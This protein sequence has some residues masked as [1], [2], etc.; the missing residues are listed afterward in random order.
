VRDWPPGEGT[1]APGGSIRGARV[2][3]LS[4]WRH[5]LIHSQSTRCPSAP[6][7]VLTS[8]RGAAVKRHPRACRRPC[9]SLSSGVPATSDRRGLLALA[10][11]EATE[12]H[13]RWR[14]PDHQC[15]PLDRAPTRGAAAYQD[16]GDGRVI[17]A[18]PSCQF[19]LG[20]TSP[21]ELASEPHGEREI[22]PVRRSSDLAGMEC[23][24]PTILLAP[25]RVPLIC[26]TVAHRFRHSR[27]SLSVPGGGYVGISRPMW[28]RPR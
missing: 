28:T 18:S 6:R 26:R 3:L 11:S 20:D 2:F 8:T 22:D 4:D 23:P 13:V 7:L 14:E 17:E 5:R 15:D 1:H 19:S 16:P 24:P 10:R 12:H 21:A 25:P 27:Y 9:W